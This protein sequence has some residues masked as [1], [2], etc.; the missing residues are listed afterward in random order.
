MSDPR[1]R[2]RLMISGSRAQDK[3]NINGKNFRSGQ[4]HQMSLPSADLALVA[5]GR[6]SI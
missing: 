1:T 3:S 2:L 6:A 4:A 5:K